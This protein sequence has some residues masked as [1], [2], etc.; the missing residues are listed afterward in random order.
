MQ[1]FNAWQSPNIHAPNWGGG[2][3]PPG[4]VSM[5]LVLLT[6]GRCASYLFGSFLASL[7]ASCKSNLKSKMLTTCCQSVCRE[8]LASEWPRREARS[9]NNLSENSWSPAL[10]RP[11][12]FLH[13]RRKCARDLPCTEFQRINYICA[14]MYTCT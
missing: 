7:G 13:V 5:E 6:S 8:L 9:V 4:E 3:A 11:L 1:A 12:V 14:S 10:V 2:G